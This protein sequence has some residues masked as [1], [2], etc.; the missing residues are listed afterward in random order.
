KEAQHWK[1]IGSQYSDFAITANNE[2]MFAPGMPYNQSHR[3]FSN[4]MGIHP[5]G[6][7]KWEDG[8]KAQAIIKNSIHL[9]DSVGP[10]YWCGYS[11]S[12]LANMKARAKDGAG[13]TKDLHIF[14]EAFCSV[15]SFHLNGDQTKSGY[16]RYQY[17]PFTLEGNFAFASGLQ[18]MLIQSYAGFIE[19]LP[20]IPAE[21]KELTFDNLR[22][23]GAFLVSVKKSGGQVSEVKIF[24]EKGGQTKLK[25]P[26]KTWFS[27]TRKGV[28]I[29]SSEPGFLTLNFKPGT[30]AIIK[31]GYE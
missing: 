30:A 20:A 14:A 17:R 8:P 23:E 10:A 31:N 22:A 18:E 16:S 9:L 21:W 24:S 15:N 4:M 6:L 25:L 12:W 1:K 26:F 13:A 3:H 11:Y 28:K 27:T 2:L 5:L 7:I 29:Y 19:V